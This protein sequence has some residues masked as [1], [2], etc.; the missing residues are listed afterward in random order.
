M[1]FSLYPTDP[2][3]V[4]SAVIDQVLRRGGDGPVFTSL[5]LPESD[6][7]AEWGGLLRD[8]H[9]EHGLQFC[10]DIS[11]L[12]LDRLG[13]G[14]AALDRLRDWGLAVL[15]IDFGF[16]PA[17]IRRIAERTGCRIAVNASTVQEPELDAL[18]GLPL[19][20]W[21]NYYPR[22]ETGLALDHYLRQDRIFGDRG[23]PLFVFLPGE[24]TFRPPIGEGLPTLEH[25]RHRTVWRNYLELRRL[26]PDSTVVCAEGVVAEDHLDWIE[27]HQ[28]TGEVTVPLTGLDPV[29][30]DLVEGPRRLRIDGARSS[31]RLEGTR[32]DGVPARRRNGDLRPRGSLQI[33]L[34]AAGRYQGEVHLMRE[35]LPLHPWQSWVGAVAGPYTGIVAELSPGQVIRPVP[36]EP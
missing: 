26:S 25:Q 1:L 15:R 20:G 5:H 35:D 2:A 7:L 19:V 28:R 34:P 32:G 16:D 6:G 23:L 14:D 3:A 29:V 9:R 18:A 11:P 30:R 17:Q 13:G 12:T 27:H 22:P 33:D 24:V 10:G 36:F 8:L 21:H 4:R 31:F